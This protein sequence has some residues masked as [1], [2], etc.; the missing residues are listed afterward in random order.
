MICCAIVLFLCFF[1]LLA[2]PGEAL[3]AA[4]DG[5]VLWYRSV[6]PVLFPFMFLCTAFL[7]FGILEHLPDILYRPLRHLF[8]CS[9]YGAF[10]ILAG[11][12]CGF[13]MG[14]KLT[15]DL[16]HL[17]KI[18]RS[19]AR[20]LYGFVNNLS[21]GFLLSY[22]AANQMRASSL[23]P[24]L[25]FSVLGSAF[26]YGLIT[27]FYFRKKLQITAFSNISHTP[28]EITD[29]SFFS[30]FDTC[31]YDTV[32]NVLKL[33][34]YITIFHMAADAARQLLPAGNP[35]ILLSVSGIEITGG[36]PL[37]LSSDFS[38]P[39]KYF[40]VTALCAFGGISALTQSIGISSMDRN[41]IFYYI[42]SRVIITLLSCLLSLLSVLFHV[43]IF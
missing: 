1:Y 21:P 37:I 7:R 29:S 43:L 6:L 25:L 35:F 26:L 19:E 4:Q 32:Q 2:C 13:P 10:T 3:A 16:L 12:F 36:I 41:M 14:A 23:G 39:Q 31:I 22:T 33:G 17:D 34:A 42:K 8:G 18:D 27:S 20:F 30:S 28:D 5:L 24:P 9:R 11:F 38:F 40:A 15:G